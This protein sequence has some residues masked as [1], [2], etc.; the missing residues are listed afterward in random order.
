MHPRRA[1]AS[2]LLLAALVVGATGC[3]SDEPTTA[4]PATAT[5]TAAASSSTA[6]PAPSSGADSPA[7]QCAAVT[8]SEVGARQVV[9]TSATQA[10]LRPAV[11]LVLLDLRDKALTASTSTAEPY[12]PAFTELVAA[13]DDVD[14]QAGA[15]LPPGADTTKTAVRVDGARLAA[16]LD[17]V[18]AV[19]AQAG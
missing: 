17:A 15:Q 6:A 3:G 12:A 5:T 11:A 10:V 2:A 1:T 14:A 4:A 16:A 19:C 18:D 8:G 9:T 7:A 13:I